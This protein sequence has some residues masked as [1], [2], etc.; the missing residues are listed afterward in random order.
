MTQPLVTDSRYLVKILFK[1]FHIVLICNLFDYA[2]GGDIDGVDDDYL[3][4]LDINRSIHDQLIE[5][6]Q[7]HYSE[8]VIEKVAYK[9]YM[10]FFKKYLD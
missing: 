2:F 5:F 6:M 8:S 7:K 10:E 4:S 3:P 1:E 9:N